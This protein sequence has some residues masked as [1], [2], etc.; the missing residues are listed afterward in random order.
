M[1]VLV[2]IGRYPPDHSG[3]GLRIMRTYEAMKARH[4]DLEYKVIAE[5]VRTPN[6]PQDP[7]HVILRLSSFMPSPLLMLRLF[8]AMAGVRARGVDL[9]HSIGPTKITVLGTFFA[10]IFSIPCITETS[11]DYDVEKKNAGG[12]LNRFLLRHYYHP[13]GAIALTPR[14]KDVYRSFGMKDADLYLRPNPVMMDEAVSSAPSS[15]DRELCGLVASLPVTF[16]HLVLGRFGGRKNQKFALDMLAHLPEEHGLVLAGPVL[17]EEGYA[18]MLRAYIVE[19]KLQHRVVLCGRSVDDP[20]LLYGMMSSLWCPSL[21]EGLPNVVL[22]MLWEGKPCFASRALGLQD[23][24]LNGK[25]GNSFDPESASEAAATV[26][27]FMEAG[28]D[29]RAIRDGARRAFDP[30]RITEET[31][32]FLSRMAGLR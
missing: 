26:R 23:Y 28:Y 6:L 22:E 18:A 30:A 10:R 20:R 17:G 4:P 24:I 9:V 19:K 12:F 1:R 5:P 25:N 3:A 8:V 13:N 31:Y 16:R 27:R 32:V 29:A 7:P 11:L 14:I 21:S 2:L 15:S